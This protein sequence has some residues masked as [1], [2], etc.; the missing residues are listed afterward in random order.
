M[1]GCSLWFWRRA[2]ATV[3]CAAS[4]EEWWRPEE[5]A[6]AEFWGSWGPYSAFGQ[7]L[8][9]GWFFPVFSIYQR[10]WLMIY[11]FIESQN[12]LGCKGP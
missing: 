6:G 3:H 9:L 1:G 8:M 5:E 12:I 2:K 7:S 4:A 11:Q 10:T